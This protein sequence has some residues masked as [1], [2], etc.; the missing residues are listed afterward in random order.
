MT[1]VT[2]CVFLLSRLPVA[3]FFC[4]VNLTF[5]LVSITLYCFV[6][7]S[8]KELFGLFF[9]SIVDFKSC[10]RNDIKGPTNRRV[11]AVTNKPNCTE[12][13]RSVANVPNDPPWSQTNQTEQMS[14][15]ANVPN[16]PL[17]SQKTNQTGRKCSVG[18]VPYD[19]MQSKT[20]T[21]QTSTAEFGWCIARKTEQLFSV[22]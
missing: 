16:D 9:Q 6:T 5:Y 10:E 12:R 21:I 13:M 14:S 1:Y 19:P 11:E 18:N 17:W 2:T 20:R 15:M 4:V 22:Y 3:H 8:L 7:V